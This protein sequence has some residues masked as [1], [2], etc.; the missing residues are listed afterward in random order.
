[1]VT[2]NE[3]GAHSWRRTLIGAGRNNGDL[4]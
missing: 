4:K 1:M 3:L 2:L